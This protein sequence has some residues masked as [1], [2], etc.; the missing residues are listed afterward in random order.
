[1]VEAKD[2]KAHGGKNE[3]QHNYKN[4][5]IKAWNNQI[6]QR[7]NAQG[8]KTERVQSIANVVMVAEKPSIALSITEA[9][10]RGKYNQKTGP[11]RQCPIYVFDG[12]FKGHNAQF[13]VTSVCG[14]VFNRD[15]P[16]T[17]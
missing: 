3:V 6:S 16:P 4:Q 9:L 2:T 15:F 1:M 14:H 12:S 10:A 11:A 7:D 13:K 8:P 17:Y 5:A